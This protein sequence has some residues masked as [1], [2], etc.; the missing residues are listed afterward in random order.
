M[1]ILKPVVWDKEE[2]PQERTWDS[3][4][5]GKF[6]CSGVV[7]DYFLC[8]PTSSSIIAVMLAEGVGTKY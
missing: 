6:L 1:Y 4:Q 7:S 5:S 3:G 8:F 2:N